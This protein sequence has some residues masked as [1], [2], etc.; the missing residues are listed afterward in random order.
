M[1]LS[2]RSLSSGLGISKL[3]FWFFNTTT[4][5]LRCVETSPSFAFK[6][7]K[8]FVYYDADKDG[9]LQTDELNA[10]VN[11]LNLPKETITAR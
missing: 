4:N 11:S 3:A 8:I 6:V 1:G 7:T 2:S 10:V 9:L 5:D